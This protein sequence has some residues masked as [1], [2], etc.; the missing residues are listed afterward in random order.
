M[1]WVVFRGIGGDEDSKKVVSYLKKKRVRYKAFKFDLAHLSEPDEKHMSKTIVTLCEILADA[2]HI[3]L[4]NIEQIPVVGTFLYT[5]G[6]ISQKSVFMTGDRPGL[7]ACLTNGF[8][9]PCVDI[10][11]LFDRLDK[12]FPIFK[13]EEKKEIARHQLFSLNIPL[14]PDS[15]A[16]YICAGNEEVCDLFY[17]AGMDI[18]SLDAAG[19]PMLGNAARVGNLPMIKWLL[20]KNANI[21]AVSKDRGYTALMDAIWKNKTD[22]VSYLVER[23]ADLSTISKDGQPVAVLASG[24]GNADICKILAENG[25]DIHKKDNLG[26]SA[27][28]YATLFNN[29]ELIKAFN[30]GKE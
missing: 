29:Q 6:L 18:D 19:T 2:T 8:F 7:P 28:E 9:P 4:V 23:G 16:H 25:A 21:D 5:L 14:N 10:D 17:S 27:L 20:S 15:F 30:A 26:M 11:D 1:K 22:L 13:E 12:Y 24:S 3:V